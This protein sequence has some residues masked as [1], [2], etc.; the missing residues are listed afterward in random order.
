MNTLKKIYGTLALLLVCAAAWGQTVTDQTTIPTSGECI[1]ATVTQINLAARVNVNGS[2][3]IRNEGS[4]PV[5]IMNVSTGNNIAESNK[6]DADG[7]KIILGY[8]TLYDMF[9]VGDGMTL[10]IDGGEGGIIIDGGSKLIFPPNF[11]QSI[12]LTKDNE[13]IVSEALKEGEGH[14]KLRRA[15]IYTA[16]TLIRKNYNC[17]NREFSNLAGGKIRINGPYKTTTI[18][19]CTFTRARSYQGCGISVNSQINQKDDPPTGVPPSEEAVAITI[20]NSTFTECYLKLY[21]DELNTDK[22]GAVF[23]FNGT[24]CGNLYM[25]NCVMEN[26]FTAGDVNSLQWNANGIGNLEPKC[27][28]KGC[29]FRNN[30][31]AGN[32]AAML[33]EGNISFEKPVTEVYNNEAKGYG[34]GIWVNGYSGGKVL[35]LREDP[36]DVDLNENLKIYNNRAGTYGGG[37][38]YRINE[39]CKLPAT[40]QIEVNLSGAKIYNN[41]VSGDDTD[42]KYNGG[43]V[44]LSDSSEPD[45]AYVFRVNL[46]GSEIYNNTAKDYGGGIYVENLRGSRKADESDEPDE[47]DKSDKYFRV[48]L[49][50]GKVYGNTANDSGGGI[51]VEKANVHIGKT[52]STDS[53]SVRHNNA[54][55]SGGGLY[56][57]GGNVEID[58]IFL[59]RNVAS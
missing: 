33:I 30:V 14:K 56:V 27:I 10:E 48:N 44:Y 46:D 55:V 12:K 26:N 5:T 50:T 49:N 19:N 4:N 38:V 40:S 3:V 54:K 34:G 58:N 6:T 35:E 13:K 45:S 24:W 16:G 17:D 29:T 21:P 42:V 37:V 51:Y 1:F 32:G 22:S 39:K 41:T 25:T 20:N 23:R 11:P 2:L 59:K 8:Y 36:I 28:M 53:L 15:C 18:E 57:H 7:N 31:A 52:E 47:S 9:R 43:G